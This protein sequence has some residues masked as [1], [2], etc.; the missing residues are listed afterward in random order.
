MKV[1]W[2]FWLIMEVL[3]TD[4]RQTVAKTQFTLIQRNYSF[5]PAV[6]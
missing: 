1:L 3:W 6:S 4:Y 2:T 5:I